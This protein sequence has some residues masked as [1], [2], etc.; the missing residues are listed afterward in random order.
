MTADEVAEIERAKGNGD[1][2]D[3]GSSEM[4]IVR[5]GSKRKSEN[6]AS[7]PNKKTKLE[8]ESPEDDDDEDAEDDS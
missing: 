7:A 1:D 5:T 3:G 6:N 8:T 2:K 4:T